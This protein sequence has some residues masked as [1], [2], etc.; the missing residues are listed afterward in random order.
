MGFWGIGFRPPI[1]VGSEA[2]AEGGLN[3]RATLVSTSNNYIFEHEDP[4]TLNFRP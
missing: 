1:H 4:H 3:K 2:E